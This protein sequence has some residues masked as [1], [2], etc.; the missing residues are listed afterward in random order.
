[1]RRKE[2]EYVRRITETGL[3]GVERLP[4]RG[5]NRDACDRCGARGSSILRTGTAGRTQPSR[6][7]KEMSLS[8]RIG[9]CERDPG[10]SASNAHLKAFG[11]RRA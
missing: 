7:G 2:G 5:L 11:R 6:E 9:P 1:M 10:P 8:D 3:C 4:H